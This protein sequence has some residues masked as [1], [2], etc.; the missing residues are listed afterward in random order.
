[1]FN[2]YLERW[3]LRVDGEPIVTYSSRLLPVLRGEE[4]AMLKIALHDEERYGG[5]LMV[6]WNG[7]GAA[8]VLAHD[9]TA[10]L[11]ERAT[12]TRSLADMSTNGQD[13]EATRIICRV[14]ALLHAPRPEPLPELTPLA[15]RFRELTP[16]ASAYGGIFQRAHQV[17][18]RLLATQQ[19]PVVLHG[20][21]H[22][23]NILDFGE[24]GWLGIDPKRIYGERG[25]DFANIFCNPTETVAL[26]P[27]RV[28]RQADVIAEAA[29]LDRQRLLQWVLAFTAL[30]AAWSLGDGESPANAL[31]LAEMVEGELGE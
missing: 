26:R 24:R 4:P 2:E 15:V 31:A 16:A 30:S 17:A 28:T 25:F 12:G 23:Q 9:D 18:E 7:R 11:L 6:W 13:D 29:N 22:H 1:M 8:R 27:G 14:A 3:G 19:D 5:G 10:L 20:D 21:L